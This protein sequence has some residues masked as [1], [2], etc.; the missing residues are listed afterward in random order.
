MSIVFIT[1]P[2]HNKTEF[3]RQL[4]QKI[5]DG[6]SLIIVQKKPRKTSVVRLIEF[7]KKVRLKR[8]FI[9]I[10]YAILLRLNPKVQKSLRYVQG[11]TKNN[12]DNSFPVKTI[13]VSSVNSENVFNILKKISPDLIV[14]WGSTILKPHILGTAKKVIN[15]HFG[16]CPFYRG[17]LANQHAILCNDFSKIGATIHYVNDKADAGDIISIIKT[18]NKYRPKELFYDLH[19]RTI[20]TYLKIITKLHGGKNLIAKKQ[21][22]SKSKNLLLSQWL[23]SVRYKLGKKIIDWE[24]KPI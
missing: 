20:K 7:Y 24:N 3:A 14:V 10:W 6:L 8:F 15:L 11:N 2:G 21:D 4:H 1:I 18:Q 19:E 17:A 5:K 9:E 22:F 12:N 23:P 13:E 16:Y